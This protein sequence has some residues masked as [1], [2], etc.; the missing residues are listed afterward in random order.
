MPAVRA[1][2]SPAPARAASC[3]MPLCS[4]LQTTK[5]QARVGGHLVCTSSASA[6]YGQVFLTTVQ[7]S[8]FI[9]QT[10]LLSFFCGF[11]QQIE[12]GLMAMAAGINLL[13]HVLI[14]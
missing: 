7:S 11:V 6:A 2:S 13:V 8:A 9:A 4:M 5:S 14:N 12:V 1:L 10:P 3:I